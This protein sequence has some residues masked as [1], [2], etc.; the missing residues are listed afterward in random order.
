MTGPIE[1]AIDGKDET[2]WTSDIGPGRS[3]VPRN[4][5][6]LLERPLEFAGG[7]QLKFRLT[8]NHGGWNSDDNMNNNLGRFRFAVTTRATSR[9]IQCRRRFARCW[10]SLRQ[11]ARR[12]SS[13]RCSAIGGPRCPSGAR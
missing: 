8:Q 9:P 13:P 4:A 12:H 1:F 5:V 2:A 3:N 10:P 6:F 7:T 11:T